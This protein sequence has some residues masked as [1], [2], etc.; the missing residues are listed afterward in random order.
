[1][2][3]MNPRDYAT[4]WLMQKLAPVTVRYGNELQFAGSDL[5]KPERH[6]IPTRH[7]DVRVYL[8][9]PRTPRGDSPVY[10]HLHG[11]AF[12]MRYPK[13]DDFL[14]RYIASEAD[15]AVVNVDFEVGPQRH[16]PVAHEQAH[17]VAA[18]LAEKGGS[19]RLDGSRLAIGG[20]SSGGNL[21]AS[22]CLQARD[23]QTFVAKLQV[24][25]VPALDMSDPPEATSAASRAMISPGLRGLVRRVYFPD[26]QTR[27]HPYASPVLAADLT[28]LPPAIVL[29][30]E[31]DV[32]RAEGDR[33]AKRLQEA[34]VETIHEVTPRADH[35]FL[36]A[37]LTRARA[38][39][40]MIATAIRAKL[41]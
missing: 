14:C 21:A 27:T 38:T 11:G 20:L 13:M 8:Y 24:L 7:G 18:W 10:V 17:D 26:K 33:Y 3:R 30:A 40:A 2:L 36:S 22:A 15:V 25:G 35:Y 29:T 34:G 28:G 23:N 39:M 9:R 1:M 41:A 16:Y 6:R 32:L 19:L 5:P 4:S 12:L 31:H 37:D